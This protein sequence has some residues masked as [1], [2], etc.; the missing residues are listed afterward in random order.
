MYENSIEKELYA[1]ST[2]CRSDQGAEAG[3]RRNSRVTFDTE[4]LCEDEKG[5]NSTRSVSPA[6]EAI[7][8]GRV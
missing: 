6:I 8:S 1:P 5:I 2:T 3:E 4:E 7:M